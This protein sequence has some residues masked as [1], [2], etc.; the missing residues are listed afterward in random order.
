MG[1]LSVTKVLCQVHNITEG[2]IEIGLD[3]EAAIKALTTEQ[4]P[5]A[6][7]RDF[8]LIMECR[9]TARQ[10]PISINFRW[11]EGHQDDK[12]K[13]LDWWARQNIRMDQKAKRFW[14]R[15]SKN[16]RPAQPMST[17]PVSIQIGDHLLTH[18]H[19]DSAY[20]EINAEAILD[21]WERKDGIPLEK[22]AQV[23]WKAS[24]Q[25]L[26][27]QPRGLQ[28]WHA[29]WATRHCA[30]GR[31]MKIRKEWA[32]STCPLCGNQEET[33]THVLQCTEATR[34]WNIT[35]GALNTWLEEQSTEPSLQAAI[36]Y[37]LQSWRQSSHT[38]GGQNKPN[39]HKTLSHQNGLGWYNFILGRHAKG[40]EDIQHRYYQSIHSKKTGF[41]WT[42]ALIKKLMNVAWDMWQHRNSV[43]HDDPENYH[44]KLLVGEAD[45]AIEQEFA[46]GTANL[47][48]EDRFLLRSKRKV[49]AGELA[50]KTRWLA[51]ISGA[52][53][54]WEAKQ[55]EVPTYDQERRA[56]EAWL[57]TTP[58]A[59]EERTHETQQLCWL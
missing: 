42:V 49:M 35:L 10:L 54:A 56:M 30:V 33:T 44:T 46:M 52:R 9:N 17:L 7:N 12:G 3:C 28:R 23:N 13:R 1:I 34:I 40:F 5:K 47:L 16:P 48:R 2:A 19:K 41:R 36:I 32:H 15:H 50:E 21:Y 22:K 38:T 43:L 27:E 53:A 18:L 4:L 29:K 8:D 57:A 26:K 45:R 25:A 6:K 55:A 24:K 59:L 20:E 31:M 39:L 37:H 14:R 11:I 51:S 58:R